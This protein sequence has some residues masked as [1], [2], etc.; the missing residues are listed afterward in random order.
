MDWMQLETARIS[1]VG[2]PHVLT[3]NFVLP[4]VWTAMVLFSLFCFNGN[5][6][7]IGDMFVSFGGNDCISFLFDAIRHH[8]SVVPV[9]ANYI[10]D[11]RSHIRGRANPIRGRA[12]DPDSP[13][14]RVFSKFK[15]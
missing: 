6:P 12:K 14:T 4:I 10:P 5:T 13:R 15:M 8:N 1:P 3:S 2:R 7:K 9:A 11:V